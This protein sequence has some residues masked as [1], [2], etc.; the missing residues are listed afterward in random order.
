MVLLVRVAPRKRRLL[1]VAV[2]ALAL[3][4]VCG[5]VDYVFLLHT[6]RP[7]LSIQTATF[8]DGGSRQYTGFG[9]NVTFR[10]RYAASGAALGGQPRIKVL[11]P[12]A[13]LRYW[14]VP[15]TFHREVSRD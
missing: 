12:Q 3:S 10:V 13:E 15:H 4:L 8:R 7:L 1:V 6:G 11:T 2:G 14:L 9:Y 5:A